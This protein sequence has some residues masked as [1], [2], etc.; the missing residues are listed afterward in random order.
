MIN[1]MMGRNPQAIREVYQDAKQW[2]D[3]QDMIQWYYIHIQEATSSHAHS[4][5][6]NG[7]EIRVK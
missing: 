1:R 6:A 3:N 2:V 5:D 7:F 4:R